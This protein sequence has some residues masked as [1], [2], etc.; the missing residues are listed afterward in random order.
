MVRNAIG[1]LTNECDVVLD[2]VA[3]QAWVVVEAT[4]GGNTRE[5]GV[6]LLSTIT[7]QRVV[8]KTLVRASNWLLVVFVV[9]V[10]RD[11]NRQSSNRSNEFEHVVRSLVAGMKRQEEKEEGGIRS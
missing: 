9:S 1:L 4:K 5:D 8:P 11:G 3:G 10:S 7:W 6:G 2:L